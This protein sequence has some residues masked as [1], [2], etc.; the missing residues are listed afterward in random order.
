MGD[1]VILR[2]EDTVD[3]LVTKEWSDTLRFQTE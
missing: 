2:L 3:S 1:R